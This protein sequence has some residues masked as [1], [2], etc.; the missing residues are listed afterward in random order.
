MRDRAAPRARV[1]TRLACGAELWIL[2]P[3]YAPAD[4]VEVLFLA[5][6]FAAADD[7]EG[8]QE[9]ADDA[10]NPKRRR[11]SDGVA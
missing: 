5:S 9:A 1:S 11:V 8:A 6:K 10:D 2:P 3:R 4:D 7:T